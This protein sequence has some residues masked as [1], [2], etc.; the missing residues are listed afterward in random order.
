MFFAENK[1]TFLGK[2]F[3]SYLFLFLLVKVASTFLPS[4]NLEVT[5]MI[6]FFKVDSIVY[7]VL[8]A[9]LFGYYKSALLTKYSK[10][11]LFLGR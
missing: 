10:I 8:I 3:A 7:G 2:V 1:I 6:V 9:Y 5:R 4:F 11:Y